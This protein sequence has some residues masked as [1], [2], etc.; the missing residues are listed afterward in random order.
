M[1]ESTAD[2]QGAADVTAPLASPGRLLKEAR[3]KAGTPIADLAR[4][5]NMAQAKLRALENDEYD[6]LPSD[7]FIQ[8]YLRRYAKLLNLDEEPVVAL[9]YQRRQQQTASSAETEQ[10]ESRPMPVP[11]WLIPAALVALVVLVLVLIF[12]NM[13]GE[14]DSGPVTEA[15]NQPELEQS[16]ELEQSESAPEPA[17]RSKSPAEDLSA[18]EPEIP[19]AEP[20]EPPSRSTAEATPDFEQPTG[21]APSPAPAPET[22]E[23][24]E[25]SEPEA[26]VAAA[27]EGTLSFVFSDDCWVEVRDANGSVLHADLAEAGESLDLEG[28]APFSV[29]LGNSRAASLL[30]NGEPFPV[31][32]RSG[33]RTSRFQVGE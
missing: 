3:E 27:S 7:V 9:F 26:P 8:G 21:S 14:D 15:P 18:G 6:T 29:M 31:P 2:Q 19:V 16:T 11:R 13:G 17:T 1:N 10:R 12:A 32:V 25:S 24:Q 30:Y 33:A 23:P 4:E 22:V 28:Q 20:A 5:L